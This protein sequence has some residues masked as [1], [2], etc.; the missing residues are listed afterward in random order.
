MNKPNQTDS[1]ENNAIRVGVSSCLLGQRVRHDGGH[2]RNHY[3]VNTLC[4]YFELEPFCPELSAGLS[5]PRPSIHQKMIA[6]QIRVVGT[7]N[8]ALDVTEKLKES[9]SKASRGMHQLSG[10]IL[11][12][13][14]PSCGMERVRVYNEFGQVTRNGRGVFAETL[15]RMHPNLPL[16]EEGR[17]CDPKLREN[18]ILRVFTYHRWQQ[19]IRKGLTVSELIEFHAKNKFNLLAHDESTYRRLGKLVASVSKDTLNTCAEEYIQAFM[20]AIKTP[21]TRKRHTNVLMHMMGFLKATLTSEDKK[22]F[23]SLLDQYRLGKIPLIVPIT[24]FKHHLRNKSVPYIMRQT[25]MQPY[26]DDLMLRNNL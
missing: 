20:Q 2:T 15:R 17:L 13:D 12:K 6:G 25:Y 19:L 7:K 26:P 11:K 22:E 8:T 18:F 1:I 5:V 16:E 3:V 21:A 24:L 23:I 14:S 9:A 4:Q 10:Y